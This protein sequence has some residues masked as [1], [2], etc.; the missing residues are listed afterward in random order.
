MVDGGQANTVKEMALQIYYNKKLF[1]SVSSTL[2]YDY[3]AFCLMCLVLDTVL[4][5]KSLIFGTETEMQ[6]Y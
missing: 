1:A 4:I 5:Q 6:I 2:L 3:F